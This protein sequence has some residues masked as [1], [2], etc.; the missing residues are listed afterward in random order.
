MT[1]KMHELG[2]QPTWSH[3]EA[4][5]IEHISAAYECAVDELHEEKLK[6]V[7][8]KVKSSSAPRADGWRVA[9]LQALPLQLL[10]KLAQVL[11]LVEETGT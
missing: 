7:C 5:F 9:E 2:T 11:N 8:K 4:A 6:N 10:V 3:F 1:F